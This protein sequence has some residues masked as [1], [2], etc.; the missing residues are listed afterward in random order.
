MKRIAIICAGFITLAA[1]ANGQALQLPAP[2]TKTFEQ[3]DANGSYAIPLGPFSDGQV[4]FRTLNGAFSMETWRLADNTQ[5][6]HLLMADLGRQLADNG[7]DILYQCAEIQ[8][9]G[10]DFRFAINII[11]EPQ[12]HVDLGDFQYLA[13]FKP[14]E[15]ANKGSGRNGENGGDY[16]SL[17]VSRSP[18]AGFIQ[19]ARVGPPR[20]TEASD[21]ATRDVAT[22]TSTMTDPASNRAASGAPIAEQLDKNGF[23]VL[24]DL[25]FETGSSD[26]GVGPFDSLSQ[27]AAYLDE[28]PESTVALVGHSDAKGSLHVNITLSENRANSVRTRMIDLHS[29][30]SGQLTAKGVGFLAPLA[31]NSTDEGR[32]QNRRVEVVLTSTQ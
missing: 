27:L 22:V 23:A 6:S 30:P 24:A 26:L 18:G 8:C 10:F 9:G 20:G 17:I 14:H 16:I 7:Y 29:L 2:A 21:S 31:S 19:I 5:A 3:V 25:V 32:T 1:G 4:A 12:M 11:P 28:H 13:A 15:D